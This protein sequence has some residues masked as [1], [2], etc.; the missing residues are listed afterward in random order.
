MIKKYSETRN[1]KY[2]R[3]NKN[4]YKIKNNIILIY[5]LK[6]EFQIFNLFNLFLKN[7]PLKFVKNT[8]KFTSYYKFT[9]LNFI[10]EKLKWFGKL[11]NYQ[12]IKFF[13]IKLIFRCK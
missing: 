4:T 10:W 3:E 8:K 5:L 6:S 2:Y 1:T 9:F 11:K 12:A 7:Y 13:P